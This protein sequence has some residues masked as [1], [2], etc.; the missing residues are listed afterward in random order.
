MSIKQ[1]VLG[2]VGDRLFAKGEVLAVSDPAPRFR[3]IDIRSPAF[4]DRAWI[5]GAKIQINVGDWNVRTYTPLSLDP[6]QGVLRIL[7]HL[8][9]DG[10][11]TRWAAQAFPGDPCRFIGPRASLRIPAI[12]SS[13]ILYGDETVIPTAASFGF[14]GGPSVHA[15]FAVDDPASGPALAQV[16]N[17]TDARF[18]SRTDAST[19]D[20][21]TALG[22]EHPDAPIALAGGAAS[23]RDARNHLRSQGIP[24]SRLKIKIYW[25]E[26]RSGL[27]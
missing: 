21:L 6:K 15:L 2:V 14:P 13:L 5:P 11:G 7:V 3:L 23:V 10:P 16:L 26:G 17:L 24:M 19:L 27:D 1:R 25:A 18:A 4:W 22:R 12:A 8:H 9:G 20:T